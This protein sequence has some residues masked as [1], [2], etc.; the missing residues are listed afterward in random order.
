MPSETTKKLYDAFLSYNS[1]DKLS[2]EIIAEHLTDSNSL[3]VFLDKWNLIPGE[4]WQE[5]I[6]RALN[7]SRTCVVFVGPH[8]IGSWQNEEMSSALDM[9]VSKKMLRVIPVLLPGA[10]KKEKES[11][12]PLFLQRLTW[13]KFTKEI[14]EENALWRL[15]CGIKGIS[16]G[17]KQGSE[18]AFSIIC[19][20]RG[21]EI[22]REQDAHFFF[23]RDAVLQ[24]L[25]DHINKYN[26]LAVI[27]PS[28][29]GKSSLVQAGLLPELRSPDLVVS[30]FTPGTYPLDELALALRQIIDRDKAIGTLRD[31]LRNS[32]DTDEL[33]L[34]SRQLTDG[35]KRL[36]I[37]VDQF[38][39]VFT[40]GD[41]EDDRK[42]FIA[43]LLT[44]KQNKLVKVILT[45]RSDFIG[46]CATYPELNTLVND[47][48]IQIGTMSDDALRAAIEEPARVAGLHFEAGLVDQILE[49]ARGAS[50]EL[51]LI[52]YAL[53]ELWKRRDYS[54]L[55]HSAYSEIGGV[56]G[57]LVNRAEEEFKKL[58]NGEQELLRRMFV[59]RLIQPG[60]GTEDTRRRATRE[61]LLATGGHPELAEKLVNQWSSW[62]V[63]MLTSYRD[64]ARN[65]IYIDVAH[66]ALIRRW[67]RIRDWLTIDRADSRLIGQ[68]RQAAA[69]WEGAGGDPDYLYQGSRLLQ[70]EELVQ[71]YTNDL[72]TVEKT[73]VEQG[74]D[75]R[76][77]ANEREELRQKKEIED[78]R[79]RANELELLTHVAQENEMRAVKNRATAVKRTKTI[80]LLAMV[81]LAIA[82][83]AGYF[84]LDS[85]KAAKESKALYWASESDKLP[86]TQAIRL[87]EYA[88]AYSLEATPVY[89]RLVKRFAESSM[90]YKSE[91]LHQKEITSALFSPS[92][93]Q[94]LTASADN[95]AKIWNRTGKPLATLNHKD[96]VLSAVFSPNGKRILTASADSTAK[97]WER[98]GKLIAT[99]Q[100][101]GAVRSAA[102]CPNGTL[103]LT[104]SEDKTA[105]LWDRL[106]NLLATLMHQSYVQSAVFSPN[107]K[108]I[109]TAS[110]DST[111]KL[112]DRSGKLLITLKHS[113]NVHSAVFSPDGKS[114]LTVSF[115]KTAK[116]W[117]LTGKLL[118]TLK[119]QDLV[120]SAEFSPIEELILTASFDK[121]AKLWDRSGKLIAT[122]D[123]QDLVSH[124]VFSPTGN[125]ILTA[126]DKTA[127]LWNREGKLL[128]TMH[129]EVGVSSAVF[130]HDEQQV[131]TVSYDMTARL[132]ERSI[133]MHSTF[134]H[135]DAVN[136]AV[137]SPSGK[138]VLTASWDNTAKVWD[139]SGKL[140]ANL[141]HHNAVNTAVFSQN[142][143]Q[144]LTASRDSTAKVWDTSGNL[145][146]NLQHHSE[147]KTAIFASNEKLVLTASADKTAKLWDQAG[148]IHI[149]FRH[150][151]GVNTAVFSP[152]EKQ[153]LTASEDSTAKLWD[154]SGSLLATL[155][156]HKAVVSAIFSPNGMHILTASDDHT[157]KL[158]DR[159]GKPLTTLDHQSFV[160]SAVFSPNGEYILTAS[161]DKT[162]KVW[163]LSG[164]MIAILEHQTVIYNARFSPDGKQILTAC[165]DYTTKLWDRSGKI[166]AT[167][168]HAD[169]V[170]TAVFSPNGQQILTASDDNISRLSY[171]PFSGLNWLKVNN[172]LVPFLSSKYRKKY[173]IN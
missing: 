1:E 142:E 90:F 148:K 39:E 24:Q 75:M 50:S 70:M 134:N 14:T 40:Q 96:V 126:S 32:K 19:P 29:S 122:L 64:S 82:V 153:I 163:N 132:W 135:Q 69:E 60:E 119:H 61:E 7:E 25:R 173:E 113:G 54:L 12:L 31:E 23:G 140:L 156:H 36:L 128:S 146:A 130:S 34:L 16:P 57:A 27:G 114:I 103:I 81:A 137:F 55:R 159:F 21:L 44:L 35:G 121:T 172:H 104:S 20:F 105:K 131:L 49:D 160:T 98:S 99:L 33:Y 83:L 93:E 67:D 136:T 18:I 92:G 117:D 124:A 165:D 112:W 143:R 71:N 46:R 149:T 123:H 15:K 151:N 59:L 147:V 138:Q 30:I 8:S 152:N 87:L 58:T 91:F 127:K 72:T 2:V 4:P 38:E 84:A 65:E 6:S 170:N 52:E 10:V 109:L 129:H 108:Q 125:Q 47:H 102:F 78:Q 154:L 141:Q 73:F 51:P 155:N 115:G 85:Y 3:S 22:F 26:F 171:L 77:K 139:L 106:G 95:T 80:F 120:E 94:I 100:H 37:I 97:L 56:E 88:A 133:K 5:A 11:E 169:G 43:L 53:T 167:L 118:V 79:Q 145:L 86:Y 110:T 164:K 68:L 144:I 157:A 48:F 41:N 62:E 166:L 168:E 74:V 13:V 89:E 116:L 9:R 45:M 42:Q 158:W 161:E 111:A 150:G 66:E 63:R 101:K 162:A 76:D 28:G 107:G 17:R